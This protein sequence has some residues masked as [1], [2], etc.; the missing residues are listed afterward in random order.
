MAVCNTNP[1]QKQT[2]FRLE[3]SEWRRFEKNTLQGFFNLTVWPLG[4]LIKGCTLHSKNGKRWIGL[5]GKPYTDKEGN[6]QWENVLQI[7][8]RDASDSFRD[9]ALLEVDRLRSGAVE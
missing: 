2:E 8:D 5:P 3:G 6:T 9:E 7:P 4:M 1:G